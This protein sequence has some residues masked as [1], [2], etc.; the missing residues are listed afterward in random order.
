MALYNRL[1]WRSQ[2]E[3]SDEHGGRMCSLDSSTSALSVGI[4]AVDVVNGKP[5]P[6][7]NI[8][9]KA[10]NRYHYLEFDDVCDGV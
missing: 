5:C 8:D 10:R 6:S 9:D 3:I 4:L 1:A 7:R 2:G